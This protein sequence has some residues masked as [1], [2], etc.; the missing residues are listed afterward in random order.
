VKVIRR[1]RL[2][3]LASA[4]RRHWAMALRNAGGQSR[5]KNSRLN[6]SSLRIRHRSWPCSFA[7]RSAD[8]TQPSLTTRDSRL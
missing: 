4:D 3:R 5:A 6:G 8:S 2:C 1:H 7:G